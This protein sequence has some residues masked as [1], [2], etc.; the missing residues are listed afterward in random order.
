M[1]SGGVLDDVMNRR[2]T[3]RNTTVA[4][5]V[6]AVASVTIPNHFLLKRAKTT[7]LIS[8][9]DPNRRIHFRQEEGMSAPYN[10]GGV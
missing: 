2:L 4:H 6:F 10:F 8:R 9:C 5:R 3:E 7:A 1:T